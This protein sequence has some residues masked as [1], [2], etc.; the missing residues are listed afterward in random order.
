[1]ANYNPAIEQIK[2]D[3]LHHFYSEIQKICDEI[4]YEKRSTTAFDVGEIY[5]YQMAVAYIR[6]YFREEDSTLDSTQQS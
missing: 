2:G 4:K 5:G 6:K 1:M 3:M